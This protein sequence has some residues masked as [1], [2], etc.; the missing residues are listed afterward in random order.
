MRKALILFILGI[1][2]AAPAAVF[3]YG[4]DYRYTGKPY[5]LTV[6]L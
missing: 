6:D 3:A 2:I 1:L 4:T 5:D